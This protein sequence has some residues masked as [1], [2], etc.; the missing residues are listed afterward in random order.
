MLKRAVFSTMAIFL[1]L[2]CAAPVS[3][4]EF[5]GGE[6]VT[7]SSIDDDTYAAGVNVYADG[8]IG[9]DLIAAGTIVRNNANIAQDLAVAGSIIDVFGNVGDDARLAGSI[10]TIGGNIEDDLVV[11]GAMVRLLPG[12]VVRGDLTV[13]GGSVMVDGTVE[14][15]VLGGSGQFIINGQ[16]DGSV[17]LETEELIIGNAAVVG[18]VIQYTSTKEAQVN[19]GAS[20][21]GGLEQKVPEKPQKDPAQEIE[22]VSAAAATGFGVVG[23]IFKVLISIVT[24]FVALY[25]FRMHLLAMTKTTI[26]EFPRQ[27]GWGFVWA[28][29]VPI[30]AILLIVTIIGSSLGFISLIFYALTMAIAQILAMIAF[31]AWAWKLATKA[32]TIQIN[33]KNALI[34]IFALNIIGVIPI[35]GWIF[36]MVFTLG[37]LGAV[38][39]YLKNAVEFK[40]HNHQA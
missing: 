40:K 6:A 36:N 16:V 15:N 29:L 22:D 7:V 27:L 17:M 3:A 10:V 20:I 39:N 14:G 26:L 33:W 12:S 13:Y 31:G 21:A 11:F 35:L 34:G 32:N 37:A 2:L 4:A 19:E 9:G 8:E 23:F 1:A 28:I 24:V 5:R 18:G 25:F 38:V 30:A